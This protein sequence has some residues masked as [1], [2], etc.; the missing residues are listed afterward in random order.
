[1]RL[2]SGSSSSKRI[3]QKGVLIK[4]DQ[5]IKKERSFQQAIKA[6]SFQA[7]AAANLANVK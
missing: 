3:A 6:I 5:Y 1:V 2:D 4:K 7:A